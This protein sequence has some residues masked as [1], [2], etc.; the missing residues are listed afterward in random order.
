VIVIGAST[1]GLQA[2]R[3]VV[4][5]LPSDLPAAVFV[6]IHTSPEGPSLLATILGRSGPLPAKTAEDGE[7]IRQG[8]I[9]VAPPDFHLVLE[10][11]RVRLSHGPREHRFRPAI[12]PLFRTAAEHHGANAIGIVLSGHMADGSHGLMTIKHRGGIAIVQDPEDAEVPTMP[13][14]A[15]RQVK[16]DYVLPTREIGRVVT[17]LLRNARRRTKRAAKSRKAV[18]STTPER[19]DRDGLASGALNRPPSPFTCPDCGGALWETREKQLVT[20]RC[21]VGHGFTAESLAEG[22]GTKL[23]D[24]L[25][26]ALRALEEAIELRKRM[27]E[28]S[29]AGNLR[30]MVPPLERDIAGYRERADALRNLLLAGS[31]MTALPAGHKARGTRRT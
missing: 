22:M 2:V 19:P 27:I 11:R 21:H 17:G 20:Y 16:V 15:M 3:T 18:E 30:G 23:E 12:D 1:G 26:S 8:Q 6:V 4:N 10:R 14:T 13:L 5:G 28:R 31:L 7:L 29:R 25:W 24:T 9:Y